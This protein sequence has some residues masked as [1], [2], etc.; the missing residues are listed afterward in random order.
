MGITFD[1]PNRKIQLTAGTVLVD[2]DDMYSQWVDWFLTGDNSKYLPAMRNVGGDPI[3]AIKNLGITFFLTNGWR[4]VPDAADHRLTLNG[5][6]VT[7][8]SGFSPVDTVPGYSII[9]EYSVSNLVDSTLA[10]MPE[11]EHASFNDYV[12][13][14]AV[15]GVSGTAYP[16]GT[17]KQPVNNFADALLIAQ[18]RGFMNIMV[19]NDATLDSGLDYSNMIIE[20]MG[21]LLTHLTVA[22][23]ANVSGSQFKNASV[24]GTLDTNAWLEDCEIGELS[25]LEGR[26][27]R[28][29]LE[30]ILT[31]GGDGALLIDCY[32]TRLNP[33]EVGVIDVNGAHN[34]AIHN[35]S[36]H[37]K[38]RNMTGGYVGISFNGS[39]TLTIENTCTGGMIH[40]MGNVKLTNNAAG[41]TVLTDYITSPDGI[42]DAV[43]NRMTAEEDST[44]ADLL[45]GM[46]AVLMGKSS[47]GGTAT[48]TFRDVN[49][50]KDRVV[51]TVDVDGNRTDVVLDLS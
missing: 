18:E 12:T 28:C 29:A 8:P 20:G 38:I 4:I 2:I 24:S 49:D 47:G 35:Y 31:I 1:G 37:L 19:I 51:A 36:G 13:V 39:G 44:F 10:Q 16:T 9:V 5:N 23:A 11:I 15:D 14:D 3:S 27:I 22:P 25:Y 33:S 48:V 26:L 6:L 7:D 45:R 30:G 46:A 40:A 41:A 34:I 42:A 50:V 43:W 17:Q 21:P 32:S